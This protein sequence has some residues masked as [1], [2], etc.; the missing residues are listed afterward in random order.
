M[1]KPFTLLFVCFTLS[2]T[3]PQVYGQSFGNDSTYSPTISNEDTQ[4]LYSPHPNH[5]ELVL[6]SFDLAIRAGFVDPS[7]IPLQEIKDRLEAGVYS[8][9]FEII[10]GNIGE[11][12]PNPWNQGPD[13]NFYGQYPFSKIPY[14]SYIDTLSGWYRGLN[15]GY[16]PIQGFLWPGA[17]ET[18]TDWANS[19]I[20]SFSWDNLISLYNS[21]N[22]DKAYEC[23]GHLLHLLA[24][25]SMPSHVKVVDHGISI[26]SLN[27]GTVID[28]D[29]LDLI[30]DEYELALAG[31]IPLPGILYIPNLLNQFRSALNTAD[32]ANIPN[33]SNWDDYITGLAQFTYSHPVVNQ[34]YIAPAQN[35]GWGA[36]LNVNGTVINPTQ[37]G[38]TPP[39][40]L[41][42]RW[43]QVAFKST[44]NSNG[45]IITESKMLE[46]CDV[47]VPKAVEYGAGLLLHFCEKITDVE[48]EKISTED[49]I[50]FQNYPNPFNPAT[51]INYSIPETGNVDLK[52]YD[53]L[54]NEVA[55]LVNEEKV[56]G[57]YTAVLDAS[58]FASGVYMY[59]LKSDNF[60]QTKKMMVIK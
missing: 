30:I 55:T 5:R 37:Y 45:T 35:G 20:N 3:Q 13:F 56:P 28:P 12:F 8:E 15:H 21:G 1:K 18:T 43:V 58:S 26:N 4:L 10:P 34:F 23:L 32:S 31:G 16:D 51:T 49:F 59:T 33:F 11:H 42:G 57:N 9:D 7:G 17:Y 54:G 53:V 40:Q 22:E 52:V 27:S 29:L 38:I 19:Q 25:L 44:A 36:A 48:S 47:L 41:N 50:L 2:A 46:M 60:F 14:G 39:V 24:D 6:K